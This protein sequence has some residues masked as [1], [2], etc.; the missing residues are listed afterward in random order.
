M[1]V[2]STSIRVTLQP[3]ETLTVIADANSSG[4]V[5]R[6][7]D[8]G[9]G[10]ALVGAQ[11]QTVPASNTRIFGTF[12]ALRHYSI[13][14]TTGFLTYTSTILAHSY[15]TGRGNVEGFTGART[16]RAEDN[17]KILRSDD[18]S[19]VAVTVPNDLPQGFNVAVSQWGAGA[20]TFT[21]GSGATKRSS[22]SGVTA[23]YGTVSVLVMKN[24]DAASAEFVLGGDAT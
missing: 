13:E 2:T 14:A 19:A 7:T 10:A 24:A 5:R 12:A 23:Q 17:G 20:V 18:G 15:A 22:T 16:L 4:I 1:A 3:G 9:S 8:D 6:M 11:I 21:A